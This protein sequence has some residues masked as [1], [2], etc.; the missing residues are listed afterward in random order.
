MK[1][2]FHFL[3]II[4]AM[5]TIMVSCSK[6]DD[7][8][9][10]EDFVY[11]L[12][13]GGTSGTGE[14]TERTKSKSWGTWSNDGEKYAIMRF[15]RADAK[16]TEGTGYLLYFENSYK[17]TLKDKSAFTWNFVGDEL[18]IN[19]RHTNWAPVHAEYNTTELVIKG[20]YF[21]G[22]WYESSDK[23]F[24]FNYKK[25]TFNNWNKYINY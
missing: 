19:Y 17:E 3:T 24:E 25:S 21:D 4:A 8:I 5:A 12:T 7:V 18:R 9:S 13:Q 14:G 10:K 6:D 2:L 22:T 11:K 23:K 1:K 16:A 20:D 15:D